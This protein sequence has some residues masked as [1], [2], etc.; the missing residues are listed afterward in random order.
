MRALQKAA[1]GVLAIS[2]VATLYGIWTTYQ[3]PPPEL[4]KQESS[5]RPATSDATAIIDERTL[6]RAQRLS[7]L[8]TTPAELPFAQSATQLAD[9]EL[10]V[11]FA[12][13]LRQIEAHP[14]VLSPEAQKIADRLQGSR[15]QL[16]A[17]KAKGNHHT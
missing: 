17:D 8:A 5:A 2:L 15:K 11:A 3:P 4:S 13:A 6:R 12:A 7:S 10:D 1:A 14:P 16:D 9:H